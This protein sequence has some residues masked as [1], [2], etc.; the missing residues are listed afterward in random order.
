MTLLHE[1][2][3]GVTIIREDGKRRSS[4][5]VLA[6]D[7]HTIQT[8]RFNNIPPYSHP[9]TWRHVLSS[10]PDIAYSKFFGRKAGFI[11]KDWFPVFAN[12]RRNGYDS[13]A[14]R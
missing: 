4:V 12:Y 13:D 8:Y 7:G 14:L 3:K 11:Y 6:P 10:H 2:S 1:N 9:W 5:K